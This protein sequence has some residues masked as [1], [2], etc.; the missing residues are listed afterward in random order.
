MQ[1]L[2]IITPTELAFDNHIIDPLKGT[3]GR[4]GGEG[5]EI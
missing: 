2:A 3:G 1:E 5:E 4:L